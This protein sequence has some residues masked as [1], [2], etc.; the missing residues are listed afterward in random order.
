MKRL[1]FGEFFEKYDRILG[2]G[3]VIERLRRNSDFE[4]DPHIVNSGF[5]Y[6]VKKREALSEIY[7]QY[8][9]IGLKYDLPLILSRDLDYWR[10]N[11]LG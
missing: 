9:D 3:A 5:I 10:K 8:L 2:E 7:R 6:D 1:P 11:R 4:L